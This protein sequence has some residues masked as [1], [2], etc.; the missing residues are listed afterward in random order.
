MDISARNQDIVA[1]HVAGESLSSV[2][3]RYF[4]SR[5]GARKIFERTAS[6]DDRR[7]ALAARPRSEPKIPKP[8]RPKPVRIQVPKAKSTSITQSQIRAGVTRFIAGE[9]EPIYAS[10]GKTRIDLVVSPDMHV[11][12]SV[13]CTT[14]NIPLATAI[15]GVIAYL[16]RENEAHSHQ[17]A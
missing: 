14:N 13:K 6:E 1:R 10:F 15:R 8:P 16:E 4:I 12:L 11:K 17:S 9:I 2:G 7:R 3:K 5:E